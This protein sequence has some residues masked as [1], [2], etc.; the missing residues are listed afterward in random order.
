MLEEIADL[1]EKSADIIGEEAYW[2]AEDIAD[3]AEERAEI[4]GE[5]VEDELSGEKDE[6]HPIAVKVEELVMTMGSWAKKQYENVDVQ[7]MALA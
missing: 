7:Q 6:A 3:Y 1:A 4:F 2:T 5:V